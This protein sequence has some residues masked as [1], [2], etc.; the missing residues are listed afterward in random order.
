MFRLDA[1][2]GSQ[3]PGHV[4]RVIYYTVLCFSL[5]LSHPRHAQHRAQHHTPP[6]RTASRAACSRRIF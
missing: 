3:A 2:R 1:R 4:A 5:V 6:P